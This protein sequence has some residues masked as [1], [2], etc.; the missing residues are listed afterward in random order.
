MNSVASS[1]ASTP[2]LFCWPSSLIA[3]MPGPIEPCRNPAVLEKTS[4]LYF[5]VG[6]GVAA[7]AAI[8]TARVAT[9]PNASVARSVTTLSPALVRLSDGLRSV[10]SNVPSPSRSHA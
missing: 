8:V 10:V 4:T 5:L 7:S 3:V 1:I 2:M 9:P 6:S